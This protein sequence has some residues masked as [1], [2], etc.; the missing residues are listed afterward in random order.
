MCEWGATWLLPGARGLRQ[1][2]PMSPYLFVLAMEVLT[3]ILNQ[4]IDQDGGFTYHW[5]CE[6]LRLFQ[7]GFADDLLLF[8]KADLSSIHL[9][10]RGLLEFAELSGLQVN[11]QK[12]HIILSRSAAVYRD[13]LLPILGYQEGHL[14]LRYLGLPLLASRLTIADC[15][16][17]LQKIDDRIRGWDGIM[18]SFTGRL[19][20]IKSVL[21]ALQ[22][23][24]AMA[25]ILPKSI[26][27]EIEKRLSSFLWKGSSE[28][29][30]AKV[31]WRQVDWVIHYRLRNASIWTVSDCTGSW[32]W[33]KLVRL[34]V[35]L[36]PCIT[37]RVG[38]GDSFSLWHDPW[39]DLGPLI[40]SFPL[41]PQHTGTLSSAPLSLV[42]RDDRWNWP[43]ITD[44]ESID[45]T[46]DLPAIHGGRDRIIWT[47]PRNSFSSAAAYE[48]Y[49][50][51]GPKVDCW[52]LAIRWASTRWRGRH[53]VTASYRALLASL[54]YHIWEERNYR[55]F[56]QTDRTPALIA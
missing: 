11:T 51:S 37:Y 9:F 49:C 10:K 22:V 48:V 56:Q 53:I 36:R 6:D 23:Y 20:L 7:L 3:L 13:M 39:H 50:P 26:I 43:H 31:S 45:I 40:T 35:N 5:R 2:D 54:I 46:H 32:S 52:D 18:L 41:G 30:Y 4:F 19:Q 25:F 1:G 12:S 38:S 24:W 21:T 28:V 8:S 47:G 55:I 16:P 14:P 17:I 44:M 29:G 34:R 15:K 33:R 27:K 42:I